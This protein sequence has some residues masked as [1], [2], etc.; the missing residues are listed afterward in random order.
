MLHTRIRAEFWNVSY[1]QM[2]DSA[3]NTWIDGMN[4]TK[5]RETAFI[6]TPPNNA[7]RSIIVVVVLVVDCGD[8]SCDYSK[9]RW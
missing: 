1:R 6:G 7:A 5:T 9:F 8:D 4:R 3:P 2:L